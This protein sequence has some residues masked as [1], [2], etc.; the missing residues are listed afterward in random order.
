MDHADG[1][2]RP[3][4]V[5][6]VNNRFSSGD[7]GVAGVEECSAVWDWR[8]GRVPGVRANVSLTVADTTVDLCGSA[9]SNSSS[10]AKESK[11]G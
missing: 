7:N 11:S 2:F 9:L 1:G 10:A 8:L 5:R 4:L 6:R 3:K